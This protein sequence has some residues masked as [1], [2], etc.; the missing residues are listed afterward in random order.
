LSLPPQVWKQLSTLYGQAQAHGQALVFPEN[1]S[2]SSTHNFFGQF[3]SNNF[4]DN[5]LIFKL[6]STTEQMP[7][8]VV[9]KNRLHFCRI[10]TNFFCVTHFF[11]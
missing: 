6:C 1:V 8:L 5:F 11:V 2:K 9:D 10:T 4:L 7:A 3:F